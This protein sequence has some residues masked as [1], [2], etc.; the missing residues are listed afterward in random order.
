MST[1]KKQ[2]KLHISAKKI[3]KGTTDLFAS[4]QRKCFNNQTKEIAWGLFHT[5][6]DKKKKKLPWKC[7]SLNAIE[8]YSIIIAIRNNA[9]M[10]NQYNQLKL[11]RKVEQN[12]PEVQSTK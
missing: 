5:S 11:G 3:W 4:L 10:K 12:F 1:I 9:N 6:N 8:N 2:I 7:K